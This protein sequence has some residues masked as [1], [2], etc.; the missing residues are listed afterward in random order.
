MRIA[1]L[2]SLIDLDIII[3]KWAPDAHLYG[4]RNCARGPRARRPRARRRRLGARSAARAADCGT[5]RTRRPRHGGLR[6]SRRRSAGAPRAVRQG[7]ADRPEF[8]RLQDRHHR[9]RPSPPRVES[10]PR[11]QRLRRRRRS[12]DVDRGG[13]AAPRLHR[14]RDLVG[15]A[16]RRIPRPVRRPRTISSRE[17]SKPSIRT[18]F[19]DDSLRVLRAVQFAARFELTLDERDEGAVPRDPAR[20]SAAGAH[21]GR[22]R[23]A[24]AARRAAV[25]R[26][27]AR[28]GARRHRPAV[29]G[30]EGAGRMRAGARVAS[31]KATCGCTR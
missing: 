23:K 31:R 18:T 29:S 17:F 19:G 27:R 7:R 3:S 4:G 22:D 2:D 9:H 24:A 13:G 14:Q 5:R 21:L 12:V 11:A 20:R 25:D 30:I 16:H 28:A 26:I 6:H 15:S 8:P 1:D 10:G